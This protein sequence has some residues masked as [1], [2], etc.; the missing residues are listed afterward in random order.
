MK[1]I[2]WS[3]KLSLFLL[4]YAC[5][6]VT[7]LYSAF[8]GVLPCFLIAN[9]FYLDS[10]HDLLDAQNRLQLADALLTTINLCIVS[11]YVIYITYRNQM[12]LFLK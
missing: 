11:S 3:G 12:L 8:L 10:E 2:F 1:P 7:D 5:L 4:V 6:F 9:L